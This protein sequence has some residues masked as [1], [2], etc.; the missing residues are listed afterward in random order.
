[1][2]RRNFL[3]VSAVVAASPLAGCSGVTDPE[4]TPTEETET[5]STDE[6]PE[7]DD[8]SD[9][10][11]SDNEPGDGFPSI[12]VESDVPELDGVQLATSIVRH[13]D[14]AGPARLRVD[15]LNDGGERK[16]FSFG[17]FQ[18]FTGIVA[19]SEE[20]EDEFLALIPESSSGWTYDGEIPDEPVDD[21]WILQ[22]D[23]NILVDDLPT[24]VELE[25]CETISMEYDVY[26]LGPNPAGEDGDECLAEGE[27]RFI[28]SDVGEMG[29]EWGFSLFVAHD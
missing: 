14:E 25:A 5:P 10:D 20:Q 19:E 16:T 15:F 2:E 26:D 18:P 7:C 28:D 1:M 6:P 17:S 11:E 24:E 12:S 22:D 29:Y 27:Y 4:E 8:L 3:T 9:N 21:C 23:E 13:F